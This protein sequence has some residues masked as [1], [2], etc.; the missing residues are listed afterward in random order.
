MPKILEFEKS[1]L[2]LKL[3]DLETETI[4][5][6]LSPKELANKFYNVKA[7]KLEVLFK[8]KMEQQ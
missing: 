6:K 5:L 8:N 2:K 7:K 4:V 3:K 1:I